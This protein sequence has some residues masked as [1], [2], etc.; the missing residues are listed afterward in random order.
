MYEYPKGQPVLVGYKVEHHLIVT[1]VY[2]EP[3]QLGKKVGEVIDLAVGAEVS[4][5]HT[6]QFTLSDSAVKELRNQALK[7]AMLDAQSRSDLMAKTLG[8]KLLGISSASEGSYQSYPPQTMSLKS[9]AEA[10]VATELIPSL[11]KVQASV[12]IIYLIGS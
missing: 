11:F 3:S 2:G 5:V 9:F 8:V 10:R 7:S 1:V 12:Q 4:Q 6:M